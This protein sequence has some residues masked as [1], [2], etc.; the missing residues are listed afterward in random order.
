MQQKFDDLAAPFAKELAKPDRSSAKEKSVGIVEKLRT[1]RAWQMGVVALIAI[2]VMAFAAWTY[3]KPP[4]VPLGFALSNGRIEAERVDISTKLP[5]RIAEVL[6]REGD[7]VTL[8]QVLARMDTLELAA[9]IRE[10]EAGVRQAEQQLEQS[11]AVFAQRESELMLAKQQLERSAALVDKGY[12]PREKFETRQAARETAVTAVSSAKA[13]IALMKAMIEASIAKVDSL[14]TNF[15]DST[16]VAPRAGR[17]QYKLAVQGEV[18]PA[19]G[20][21]LTLL[22][23]G[24]VYMT[25]FLP[26]KDVGRLAMGSEARIILDAAPQ[27]VLPATV[28]FVAADAQFTPKYVETKTEREKLMFR[29]KAQLPRDVLEAHAVLVKT[30]IPGVAYVRLTGDAAWP[31]KLA[32]KLPP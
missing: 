29:V 15:V 2:A 4:E 3:L 21:V 8:G 30:G 18:M 9:Q 10:A 7:T 1:N 11:H 24:D 26:A 31:A 20:K 28:S 14:K 32:V 6:V 17:I 16:L 13:Q 12:T 23:L 5:G 25:I 27:Y 22:D 19:G